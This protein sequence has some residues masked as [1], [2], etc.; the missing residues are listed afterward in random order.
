M[1]RIDAAEAGDESALQKSTRS[2]LKIEIPSQCEVAVAKKWPVNMIE[3]TGVYKASW[4]E[5]VL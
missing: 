2:G 4:S 1:A 5:G 3:V